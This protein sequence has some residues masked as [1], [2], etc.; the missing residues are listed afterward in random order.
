[1]AKCV[2]YVDAHGRAWDIT[3]PE[4]PVLQDNT[5]SEWVAEFQSRLDLTDEDR[6]LLAD[7]K[8]TV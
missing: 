8:V 1:M 3:N 6:Q 7:L 5:V 4:H 2:I